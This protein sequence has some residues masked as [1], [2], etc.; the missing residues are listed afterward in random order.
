M[1][2]ISICC[3]HLPPLYCQ[4]THSK[5]C[6]N[7]KEHY[8]CNANDKEWEETGISAGLSSII[9]E[10]LHGL[11]MGIELHEYFHIYSIYIYYI[12]WIYL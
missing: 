12:A 9:P 1:T 7:D 8:H 6:W 3:A 4:Y 11:G 10:Y 2:I 5:W